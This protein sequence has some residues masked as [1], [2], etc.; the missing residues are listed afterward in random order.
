MLG[1]EPGQKNPDHRFNTLERWIFGDERSE[2]LA[3]NGKAG[4]AVKR[5]KKKEDSDIPF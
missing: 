2:W 5:E 4:A 3:K 1:E